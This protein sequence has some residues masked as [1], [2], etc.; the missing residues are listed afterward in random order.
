MAINIVVKSGGFSAV[1]FAVKEIGLY[2]GTEKWHR[3]EG[4]CLVHVKVMLS[5][6]S[7]FQPPV[8]VS[9]HVDPVR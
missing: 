2:K 4:G 3:I 1:F 5:I 7:L 6:F 9:S 8:V